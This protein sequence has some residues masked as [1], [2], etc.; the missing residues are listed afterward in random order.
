[1]TVKELLRNIPYEELWKEYVKIA[2][3]DE[4]K[5]PYDRYGRKDVFDFIK[6]Y[7]GEKSKDNII[8]CIKDCEKFLAVSG[9]Y[10]DEIQPF[11]ISEMTNDDLWKIETCSLECSEIYEW[12]DWEV[13][14]KSIETYGEVVCAA[15]ILYEMTYHGTTEED[16]RRRLKWFYENKYENEVVKE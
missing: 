5:Y 13:F 14:Q 4:E 16:R 2:N 1:M 9:F 12:A 6:D 3:L 11:K 7:D 15:Y 10:S 8:V